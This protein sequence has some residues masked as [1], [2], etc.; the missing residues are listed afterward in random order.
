MNANF[1]KIKKNFGFGC[2]RL[3]MNGE[4]VDYEEFTKMVDAYLEAGF[5]Y[6][7]TAHVYIDGKSETAIRDCLV[8]RHPRESYIL[9]NKLTDYCFDKEEDIRPLFEEQLKACGVDYFDFYLMHAQSAKRHVK[10]KKETRAYEIVQELIDEGKVRH[11]GISFHDT[12]EVLD[13]ILTDCPQIEVVQLQ[14]NYADYESARVQS[15]LCYEVCVK[16]GKPVLVMEPVKGGKLVNLPDEAL[17][18]FEELNEN[19][20][21]KDNSS[22]S[23]SAASKSP[24]SYAIRYAASF[25]NIMMV[26]S[27]MSDMEQM[28][29]NLSYMKEF[30]PLDEK[31]MEGIAKVQKIL[32][33][34]DTIPCTGCRY[35]VAGCPKQIEIPVLFDYYNEKKQKDLPKDLAHYEGLTTNVGKGKASDC[36]RCGKCEKECPQYLQIRELLEKVAG[37]LEEEK[38]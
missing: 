15:R 14:F 5:N 34:Q 21:N 20:E 37:E 36:I 27:G 23:N 2:M 30:K 22:V 28:N 32:R 19:G 8:K 12:A 31:E 9:V 29:D 13:M 18:V 35:C 24:A 10:Y 17:R 11:M 33:E 38:K 25:E 26:L 3:P 1:E 4:E 7:D 6:F 16:H